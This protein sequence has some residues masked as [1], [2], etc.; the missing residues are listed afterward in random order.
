MKIK[1][2]DYLTFKIPYKW[3]I[4]DNNEDTLIYKNN[5][6]GAIVLSFY[7][8]MELQNGIEEHISMMANKF[9]DGNKINLDN[10]LT[11]DCTKKEKRILYGTGKTSDNDFIKIWIIAKY[12]KVIIATYEVENQTAE[13]KQVDKILDSFCFCDKFL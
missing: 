3:V 11:L 10:P 2:K 9:I 12:P 5:G 1:H 4:E 7:T 8:I 6:E 13:L